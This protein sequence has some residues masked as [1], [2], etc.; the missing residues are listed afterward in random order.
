MEGATEIPR[1]VQGEENDP[2]SVAGLT[3]DEEGR[4]RWG[5]EGCVLCLT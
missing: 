1:N 2:R 4:S 3:G 5:S